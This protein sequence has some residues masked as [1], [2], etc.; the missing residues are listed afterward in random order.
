MVEQ[1]LHGRFELSALAGGGT[2]ADVVL[3]VVSP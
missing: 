1:G 3:P 2:R